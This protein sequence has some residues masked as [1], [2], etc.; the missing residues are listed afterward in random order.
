MSKSQASFGEVLRALLPAA[1]FFLLF[2]VAGIVHVTGRVLVVDSGYALSQLEAEGR[3]L[4]REHHRLTLER[5]TLSG[6]QRLEALAREQLGM[7][8]PE[9]GAL[10]TLPAPRQEA[11]GALAARSTR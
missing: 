10:I 5:A 9:A 6:P 4:E 3:R 11:R 1:M 7:G 2:A 8:P